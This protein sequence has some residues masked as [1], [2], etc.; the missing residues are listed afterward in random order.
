MAPF[1]R[2]FLA[3]QLNIIFDKKQLLRQKE[4]TEPV[5]TP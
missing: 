4:V 1:V 3:S 5:L 2:I